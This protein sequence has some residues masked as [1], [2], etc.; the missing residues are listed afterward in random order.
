MSSTVQLNEAEESALNLLAV[1]GSQ[2]RYPFARHKLYAARAYLL[3]DRTREAEDAKMEG[4]GLYFLDG[5]THMTAAMAHHFWNSED[6][7]WVN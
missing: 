1:L 5:H 2:A 4:H 3:A 7:P 6:A